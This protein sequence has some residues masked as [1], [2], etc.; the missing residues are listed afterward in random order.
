MRK[1]YV[2]LNKIETARVLS[3]EVRKYIEK[4]LDLTELPVFPGKIMSITEKIKKLLLEKIGEVE[5][6]SFPQ[7]IT[8][9]AFPPCITFLYNSVSSGRHLSHIGRF[10]LTSFLLNIGM[11][12]QK[13]IE[14]FKN[15]SDYNE[16]MTSYQ[17]EHIAGGKGSKT[18]YKPPRC[19]T[20]KTHGVCLNPDNIC[21]KIKHPLNYYKRKIF[22]QKTGKTGEQ[23]TW[24]APPRM[25]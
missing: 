22:Y 2:Y 21:K 25:F 6:P 4:K 8:I 16:R 12:Q 11:S 20:L 5:T 14:I 10:T 13:I 9:N 18:P 15:F 19:G 17:V 7:E 3:E 23:K 1:G 24:M